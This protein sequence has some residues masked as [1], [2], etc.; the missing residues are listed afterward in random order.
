MRSKVIIIALF[1]CA[2]WAPGVRASV[3]VADDPA[4]KLIRKD[5]S[6]FDLAIGRV[7]SSTS[8]FSGAGARSA[9]FVFQLPTP[10]ANTSPIV[11]DAKLEFT[12]T[13]DQ[14]DGKYNIDLSALPARPEKTVFMTDNYIGTASNPT[15]TLGSLIEAAIV[16]AA[17]PAGTLPEVVSTSLSGSQAL[18]DYLNGQYGTDGSGAGKWV[19][20][21]LNPDVDPVVENS[22]VDVAFAENGTGVPTLTIDFA[23]EPTA[24]PVFLCL[25]AGATARRRKR[26][27][28]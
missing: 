24:A 11:S 13:A 17:H 25:A 21:R 27:A 19:F 28:R 18:V 1:A 5:G 2:L 12:I 16:P 7:G 26:M 22:G 8:G 15:P 10:P 6:I 9:E 14:P 4:D 23:P 3:V 20:L